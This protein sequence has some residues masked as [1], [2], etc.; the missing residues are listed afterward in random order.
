[1]GCHVS[2][3]A[4]DPFAA[5]VPASSPSAKPAREKSRIGKSTN[6]APVDDSDHEDNPFLDPINDGSLDKPVAHRKEK[7]IVAQ[8]EKEPVNQSTEPEAPQ[9]AAE[10]PSPKSKAKSTRNSARTHPA[11]SP[12]HKDTLQTEELKEEEPIAPAKTPK[13]GDGS[14]TA[15]DGARTSRVP[16]NISFG[17]LM[18]QQPS[19]YDLNQPNTLTSQLGAVFLH[20]AQKRYDFSH[21]LGHQSPGGD[22]VDL[23]EEKID[24]KALTVLSHDCVVSFMTMFKKEMSK[25]REDKRAEEEA[26]QRRKYLP[27]ETVE[28]VC[29]LAREYLKSELIY[30]NGHVTRTCF[31]FHFPRAFKAMFVYEKLTLEHENLVAKWNKVGKENAKKAAKKEKEEEEAAEKKEKKKKSKNRK[32]APASAH[33]DMLAH[34][35][36]H[37]SKLVQAEQKLK[38]ASKHHHSQRNLLREG[39]RKKLDTDNDD[40]DD[41]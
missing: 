30:K 38:S 11:P 26:Y 33:A 19:S 20:Y 37:G 14:R 35:A 22:D 41:D 17:T 28:E 24:K 29:D 25:V 5:N 16:R 3:T 12:A 15:R 6:K 13:S 1:M 2:K 21:R 34:M 31:F 27:G 36:G 4:P 32:T 7:I 18:E 9:S 40:D 23:D 39:S 10:P 8:E